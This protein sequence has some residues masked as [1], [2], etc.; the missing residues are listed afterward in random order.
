MKSERVSEDELECPSWNEH[1]LD[2]KIPASQQLA[3]RLLARD[4]AGMVVRSFARSAGPEDMNLV[5]WK[6]SKRRPYKVT[7]FDPD[8]RLPQKPSN[9]ERAD[10]EPNFREPSPMLP[11][12]VALYEPR[13]E[14]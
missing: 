1:M 7:V 2:G 14:W 11:R 8:H 3:D 13:R 5:L 6:W 10:Q 9:P 4:Y 12:V